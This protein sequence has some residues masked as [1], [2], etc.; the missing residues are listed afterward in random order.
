[1]APYAH[2]SREAYMG[3]REAYTPGYPPTKGEREAYTPGIHPE[4]YPTHPG[5]T[6]P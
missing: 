5:Y 4:V 1:M 3:E 2:G 6:P